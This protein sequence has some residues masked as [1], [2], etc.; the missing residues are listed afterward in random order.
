MQE[1][2]SLLVGGLDGVFDFL[3]GDFEGFEL[4]PFELDACQST[5]SSQCTNGGV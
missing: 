3:K 1:G 2:K 5:M 4:A